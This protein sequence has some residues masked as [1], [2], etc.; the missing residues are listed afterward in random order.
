MCVCVCVC[1]RVR[2][3]VLEIGARQRR[4]VFCVYTIASGANQA[5]SELSLSDLGKGRV[6]YYET[7]V[8]SI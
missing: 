8:K 2:V 1:A 5:V 3:C 6:H 4:S 7:V